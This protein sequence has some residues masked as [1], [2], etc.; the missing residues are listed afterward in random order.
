VLSCD[1]ESP[2][3][4]VQTALQAGQGELVHLSELLPKPGIG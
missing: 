2:I 3:A 4:V 1:E